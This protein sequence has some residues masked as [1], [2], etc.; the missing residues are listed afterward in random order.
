MKPLNSAAWNETGTAESFTELVR[1]PHELSSCS[2]LT[3]PTPPMFE[4]L[5]PSS[6]PTLRPRDSE[7][8]TD[9]ECFESGM[10]QVPIEQGEQGW[11]ALAELDRQPSRQLHPG[12]LKLG[13]HEN[14]TDGATARWTVRTPWLWCPPAK[15]HTLHMAADAEMSKPQPHRWQKLHR[16]GSA[17]M[18][19][20]MGPYLSLIPPKHYPLPQPV[21]GETPTQ[22]KRP[23]DVEIGTPRLTLPPTPLSALPE[24]TPLLAASIEPATPFAHRTETPLH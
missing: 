9:T 6:I 5:C 15:L 3:S 2:L 10:L 12:L 17:L 19:P 18:S 24:N 21:D 23:N 22:P 20:A 16:V 1:K 14:L 11:N 7:K 4:A 13:V 8:P